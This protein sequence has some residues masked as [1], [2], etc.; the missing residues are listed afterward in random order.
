MQATQMMRVI[1]QADGGRI[2]AATASAIVVVIFVVAL[3]IA[4]MGVGYEGGTENR[5]MPAPVALEAR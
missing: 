4:T 3:V 5:P 2:L 1:D